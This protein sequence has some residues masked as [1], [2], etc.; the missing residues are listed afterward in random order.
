MRH[1]MH[2][3]IARSIAD[4]R[5]LG[6]LVFTILYHSRDRPSFFH[7]AYWHFI[8]DFV[9]R[10]S[11]VI[12]RQKYVGLVNSVKNSGGTAHIFSSMHE[13]GEREYS[14]VAFGLF[15]L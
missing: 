1:N 12:T 7:I 4:I 3:W 8:A 2:K 5:G 14:F 9:C 10:N 13:S 6:V 15:V 11:D